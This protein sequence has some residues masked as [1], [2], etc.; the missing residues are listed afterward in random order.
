MSDHSAGVTLFADNADPSEGAAPPEGGRVIRGPWTPTRRL[1]SWPPPSLS[2]ALA[3][4]GAPTRSL[5][6]ARAPAG[7][8]TGSAT[9]VARQPIYDVAMDVHAYELLFRSE[10]G[11]GA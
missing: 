4:A 6:Q 3:R 9:F 11:D 1:S 8:P 10:A 5:S 7:P 2:H